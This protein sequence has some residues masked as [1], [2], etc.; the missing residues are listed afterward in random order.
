M[1]AWHF[2]FARILVYLAATVAAIGI[3]LAGSF[4]SA[5]FGEILIATRQLFGLWALALLLTSM[6]LAPLTHVLPIIPWRSSLLYSRR[7]IG[8][9]AALFA[10]LHVACY[11]WS[12][13]RRDWRELYSP[14]VLWVIGLVVGIIAMVGM[15]T[16]TLTSTDRAVKRMGGRRWKR[17]HTAVYFIM[18]LVLVHALF[19][20]A[21]FGLNR[22]PDVHIE[23]D[24][25]AGIGFLCIA[26]TWLLL[27]ILRR[28]CI[29]FTVRRSI[30]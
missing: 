22:A 19:V 26:A 3:V 21:D 8:I 13:L 2:R 30:A 16:L 6:M 14:G 17:L 1:K 15:I 9:C 23:A 5:G 29:R 28:K 27:F 25:G 24:F 4:G 20:G 18:P 7:A 10:I 12:V 11:V